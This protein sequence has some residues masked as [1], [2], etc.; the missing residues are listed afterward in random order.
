MAR[1]IL[2][3]ERATLTH[4]DQHCYVNAEMMADF[5]PVQEITV[6]KLDQIRE[7]VA[8]YGE[9]VALDRPRESFVITITVPR[10]QRRPTGFENA[11]RRGQLGTYAWTHDIFKHPL[12]MP[13]D[14]GVRMWGGRNRPFQLDKCTPLWPD[15]T[16]DE[17]THAAAGHMGLYGWLRA[18]NARVQRLS[19]CTHTLLDVA[20][21]AELRAAYAARR[22]PL[23][24]AQ[25]AL[26]ASPQDLAA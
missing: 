23:S 1:L 2:S 21:V 9:R 4:I 16:P 10:G 15:E 20:T 24:V 5:Y 13:G 17:F 25:D 22:H 11:Y 18:T 3:A 14:Y 8:R 26:R 12:P 7:A 19:Q 6:T